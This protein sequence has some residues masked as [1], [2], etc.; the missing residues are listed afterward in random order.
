MKLII[1][2]KNQVL[3]LILLFLLII[4][5]DHNINA[6]K[7]STKTRTKAR[8]RMKTQTNT[9][10][11]TKSRM[12]TKMKSSSQ[13]KSSIFSADLLNFSKNKMKLLKMSTREDPTVD[14]NPDKNTNENI[15]SK[16]NKKIIKNR[17]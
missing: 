17:K 2:Q 4:A 15:I 8:S 5:V 6:S 16:Y 9:S 7:T 11:R 3:L 12:K 10:T 13:I 1:F 14:H